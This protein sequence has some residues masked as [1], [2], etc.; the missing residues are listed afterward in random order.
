MQVRG[1][2]LLEIIIAIFLIAVGAV[3]W[4][5]LELKGLS[6]MSEM[7]L[8]D[9]AVLAVHRV[10]EELESQVFNISEQERLVQE[11]LPRGRLKVDVRQIEVS[12]QGK[13]NSQQIF[14]L[15]ASLPPAY[16]GAGVAWHDR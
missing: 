3:G 1:F 9:R 14:K 8:R 7:E 15:D 10:A 2:S 11:S 13:S 6:L 16:A 5:G 4:L 12:W